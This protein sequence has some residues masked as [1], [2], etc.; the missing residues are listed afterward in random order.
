MKFFVNRL[1][2]HTVEVSERDRQGCSGQWGVDEQLPA[3]STYS[4]LTVG[5]VSQGGGA[6]C[7]DHFA[8]TELSKFLQNRWT[9]FDN[10]CPAESS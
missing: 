8:K 10:F 6:H 2:L 1:S 4:S 3:V 7:N 5:N 9:N